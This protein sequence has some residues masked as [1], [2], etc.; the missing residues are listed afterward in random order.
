MTLPNVP[1][2]H[3]DAS[4]TIEAIERRL[5][6]DPESLDL[7]LDLSDALLEDC[8]YGSEHELDDLVTRLQ[9]VLLTLPSED[10]RPH[11]AYLSWLEDDNATTAAI[12][13]EHARALCASP[14]EPIDPDRLMA[15]FVD[16]FEP[17][18]PEGLW[19]TLADVFSESNAPPAVPLTL[20]GLAAPTIEAAIDYFVQALAEDE[21]FWPAALQCGHL[22][23]DQ[24]NWRTARGYYKRAMKAETPRTMADAWFAYAWCCGKS[25]D[26]EEEARAYQ[27]CLQINPDYQ[28]ARNNLGWSLL[29][30]RKDEAAVEV[31]EEALERG[32][33]GKYPLRNIVRGLRRLGRLDEAISYL[34]RDTF[35]GSIRPSAQKQIDQLESLLK[36]RPPGASAA[37]AAAVIDTVEEDEEENDDA[38][39]ASADDEHS[40]GCGVQRDTESSPETL[41]QQADRLSASVRRARTPSS[42][43]S[44]SMLESLIEHLILKT[45]Q[46]FGRN[47]RMFESPDGTYGRQLA[48]PRVGRIDLL[49]IDN[50]TNELVVVELKRDK[51][52]DEV[53]GQLCRYLGWVRQNLAEAQ[54]DV[55]GI[56]CVHE[57]SEQLRMAAS[58]VPGVEIYE[59][60]LNFGKV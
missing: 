22:Y 37:E 17:L 36:A 8:V 33:D 24:E 30:Q 10:T 13:S 5:A 40:D 25:G 20:R 45:G 41:E 29:K 31:F 49:V 18:P 7:K 53:V 59:Y 9:N 6:S 16:P 14:T 50:E 15:D 32:N 47:V 34:R 12:L 1:E 55:K 11:R 19:N 26:L 42:V 44:E 38:G 46:A 58:A 2:T 51:S 28:Y 39:S 60:A 56:I 54:Q 4:L 57:S 43:Q 27:E 3:S 21:S 35:R 52:S 48:I 23:A